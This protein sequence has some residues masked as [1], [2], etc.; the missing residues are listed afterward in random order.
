MDA[1]DENLSNLKQFYELKPDFPLDQVFN[2]LKPEKRDKENNKCRN[3]FFV[4]RSVNSKNVLQNIKSQS[5]LLLNTVL[6]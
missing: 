4:N 5:A 2:R 1:D 6:Y 3:L